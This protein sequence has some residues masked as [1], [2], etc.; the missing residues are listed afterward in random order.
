MR[1]REILGAAISLPTPGSSPI[2]N[3]AGGSLSGRSNWNSWRHGHQ[4]N[5]HCNDE[6][7]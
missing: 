1:G 3:L 2:G 7:I 5:R 6:V 4:E